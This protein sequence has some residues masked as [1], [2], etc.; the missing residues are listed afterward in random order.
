MLHKEDFAVIKALHERGVYQKDIA[1]QLG[2][3]PKTVSRALRRGS[4]PPRA[5][6]PRGSK[7]ELFKAQVD[8]LLAE[9]VWNAMVIW[10]ELQ[11]QGY[12]GQLTVLR[13]YI[14]PKRVLRAGKATVRFE[15]GPG[16]QLQSDWSEVTSL[17][18]DEWVKVHFIVNQLGYSR[19]FHFWGTDREDAEH[20]YEGLARSLEY[21]G[22]VPKEV[23][24]DNQKSAVLQPRQGDQPARFNERFLDMAG[25]YGFTPRACRPYRARTKGK[26]ERMA[27][28]LQQNFFVRYRSF[29]SWAH[30][31]Q[32]AERWLAEEADQRLHGTV[33]E[34]VAVRFARERPAL[35]PLPAQRYDTAYRE[36]RQVSWDSY[37][38]VRGNR[39]SA[40]ADLAGQ[41]VVVR[42]SLDDQL[43]IYAGEQLVAAHTLHTGRKNWVTVPEHHATLWE[44]TLGVQH[45]PLAVYEEATKWS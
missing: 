30:L 23:L 1:A 42:I 37:I 32:L 10:R 38:E 5:R 27:S 8:Q 15:T 28:Y 6:K 24:V 34:V 36:T 7:L 22:G 12:T 44:T 16:Q 21:L 19:R 3:D 26:I 13:E 45:R 39:Y 11:A 2:V 25:H 14:E 29:E 41:T 33:G 35:G 20:T 9:G 18:A 4:A 31:N 43:Q 17:I 40:P